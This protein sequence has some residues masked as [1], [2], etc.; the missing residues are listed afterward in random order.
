MVTQIKSTTQTAHQ[1]TS[2]TVM[3][4]YHVVLQSADQLQ[5][6][7]INKRVRALEERQHTLLTPEIVKQAVELYR[8]KPKEVFFTRLLCKVVGK[9]PNIAESAFHWLY[10][11]IKGKIDKEKKVQGLLNF[12]QKNPQ[13]LLEWV[14]FGRSP[15]T[16]RSL[17][18]YW[19][20]HRRYIIN[21]LTSTRAQ[22]DSYWRKKLGNKFAQ[23]WLQFNAALPTCTQTDVLQALD[24]ML[25]YFQHE[26]ATSSLLT[27]N[28]QA[29]QK[30][31][32]LLKKEQTTVVPFLT[33]WINSPQSSRWKSLKILAEQLAELIGKPTR[34][35]FSA[36]RQVVVFTLFDY[37]KY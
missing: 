3:R 12:L 8:S 22:T 18:N 16:E 10:M 9:S 23:E 37:Y 21:L 29:F 5:R 14:I 34:K 2:P 1:P 35:L 4:S 15:Y 33:S 17:E 6:E 36:V 11:A 24:D 32:Q 19:R 31:L 25:F 27:K 28:Q 26:F 20:H 30:K 13:Q 7:E